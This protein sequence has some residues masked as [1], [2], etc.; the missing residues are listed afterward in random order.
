MTVKE[1]KDALSA[2]KETD[3]VFVSQ[4]HG[5]MKLEG[6]KKNDRPEGTRVVLYP[7]YHRGA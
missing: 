1:L 5:L 6:M 3:Q 4:D 2:C 7:L